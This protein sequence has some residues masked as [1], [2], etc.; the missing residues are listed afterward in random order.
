MNG[1]LT[2]SA[3]VS[4]DYRTL[5]LVIDIILTGVTSTATSN[6][7]SSYLRATAVYKFGFPLLLCLVNI[8]L[9]I[10]FWNLLFDTFSTTT[11]DWCGFGWHRL[12]LMLFD[13]TSFFLRNTML[14]LRLLH[15]LYSR[16]LWKKYHLSIVS[17]TC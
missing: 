12:L 1:L 5:I 8:S 6:I 3:A 14:I 13:L 9:S 4:L 10:P 17:L 11:A 7:V 2:N 15:Y 16:V